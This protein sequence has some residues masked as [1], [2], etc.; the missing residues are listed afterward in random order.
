[1]GILLLWLAKPTETRRLAIQIWFRIVSMCWSWPLPLMRLLLIVFQGK[2]T[3]WKMPWLLC[4]PCSKLDGQMKPPLSLFGG[5]TSQHFAM[6][7]KKRL[8]MRNHGFTISKG[9]SRRRNIRK[10][11]LSLIRKLRK[12]AAKFFLNG[13][14]LY[15]RNYDSV[16]LRCVDRHEENTI[17]EEI[18][19]GSFGTHASGHTMAKKI[20]R[21]GYY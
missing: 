19:E 14:V 2:R 10:M 8:L 18:H 3:T 4:H 11:L 16:F 13:D 20:L 5:W 7:Y 21:A 1:M 12:Y 15:K 6:K 17:I 9:I